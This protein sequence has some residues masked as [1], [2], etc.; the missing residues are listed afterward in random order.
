M[1]GY[2]DLI[3]GY[4]QNLLG[5]AWLQRKKNTQSQCWREGE[6]SVPLFFLPVLFHYQQK[7]LEEG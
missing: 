5:F 4:H 7:S 6:V 2:V 3:D 1:P